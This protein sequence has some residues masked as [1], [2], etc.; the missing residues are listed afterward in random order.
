MTAWPAHVPGWLPLVTSGANQ[1]RYQGAAL[2]RIETMTC[3]NEGQDA[4]AE[5]SA[6]EGMPRDADDDNGY[7]PL[8]LYI[9]RRVEH[10]QEEEPSFWL[11]LRGWFSRIL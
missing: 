10:Q 4:K 1:Q 5:H 11:R 9:N 2:K 7:L 8:P 6:P 3:G